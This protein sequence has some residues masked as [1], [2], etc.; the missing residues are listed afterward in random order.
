MFAYED[1]SGRF[2][3]GSGGAAFT[4]AVT[5]AGP[6]SVHIYNDPS[7]ISTIALA[8]STPLA[9]VKSPENYDSSSRS[10]SARV[11]DSVVLVNVSGRSAAIEVIGVTTR[12]TTDDG[13]AK[14]TFKYAIADA[15]G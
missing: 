13:V 2:V 12:E 6:G 14:F 8:P 1:N 3:I 5:T 4:I 15:E 11:G 10:R 9:D 7:D